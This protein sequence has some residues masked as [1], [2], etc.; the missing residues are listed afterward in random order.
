MTSL[1]VGNVSYD[2]DEQDIRDHFHTAGFLLGNVTIPLD[3]ETRKRRGFAFVEVEDHAAEE[4]VQGMHGTEFQ[5]RQL[6]VNVARPKEDARGR[7]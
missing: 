4:C 2:A 1:F 3:R 7:R 5:G 6:N